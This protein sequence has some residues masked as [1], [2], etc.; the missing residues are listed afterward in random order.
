MYK[1]SI[2][3]PVYN[4]EDK[5]ERAFN[6]IYN[7]TL[8]FENLEVILVDDCSTD[9]SPE[10]IKNY[11]EKYENV[12]AICLDE[13]S[14]FAGKP[15]NIAVE[16]ATS[17]YLM[18]LDS[19]DEYFNNACEI[20]YEN[21]IN[22]DYEMVSG[23]YVRC[24]GDII[25]NKY[26][27]NIELVDNSFEVKSV[28]EQPELFSLPP[29]VWTK[30]IKKDLVL[31]NDI[32]FIEGVPAQDVYF[33]YKCLLNA[34][35]IKYVDVP[36]VRYMPGDNI[37]DFSTTSVKNKKTLFGFLKAYIEILSLFD[38][39]E[40]YKRCLGGHL[41]FWVPHLIA[42]NISKVEKID[43][44]TYAYPLFEIFK[45]DVDFK[46]RFVL[47]EF[48][49]KVYKKDFAGAVILS[50]KIRFKL[51]ENNYN[52]Y[53]ELKNRDI[54]ILETDNHSYELFNLFNENDSSVKLLS[55]DNR[56]D[57]Q[58]RIN[59]FEYY[60][61][62]FG[63][64]NSD[65]Q[66]FIEPKENE[67]YIKIKKSHGNV[68]NIKYFSS[69][70]KNDS[71]LVMEKFYIDDKLFECTTFNDGE[72]QKQSF[73][74]ED[75]FKFLNIEK[76][77]V[78]LFNR[79]MDYE[80]EFSGIDEFYNYFISEI[81]LISNE[82]PFLICENPTKCLN[83]KNIDSN[84]A[85]KISNG[86]CCAQTYDMEIIFNFQGNLLNNWYKFLRNIY[87]DEINDLND[88]PVK[89]DKL[90][91]KNK[92]LKNKINNLNKQKSDLKEQIKKLEK[93]RD[94][95]HDLNNELLSSN[96]WKLTKPLRKIKN[97]KK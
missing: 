86:Y 79:D 16:N 37:H 49:N 84:I 63:E 36:V 11:Q 52:I 85:F 75:G 76:N 21:I 12:K 23:N 28:H 33:V 32:K 68:V 80:I 94:N 48:F 53:N 3:V 73:F 77:V 34:D 74:T 29:S 24:V 60:S 67:N 39:Y 7:Q 70:S 78:K 50:E 15:R 65:F 14:G 59:I 44:L 66:K 88:L 20:L 19:D 8:G 41:D 81:C 6:S 5:I 90:E 26:W 47:R 51:A 55:F 95:Y 2:I 62:K 31:K 61:K 93:Q 46:P 18:F 38:D 89:Y 40:S 10:I 71:D 42:S 30:I 87:L 92:S 4:A 1:I 22:D 97:I 13:N 27:N 56:Y 57:S 83:I 43:L 17:E 25:Q 96:S 9:S 64:G 72:I 35:G 58:S 54:I 45:D 82:K 69:D 91:N